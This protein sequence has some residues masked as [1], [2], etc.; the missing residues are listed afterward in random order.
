MVILK[1]LQ[2]RNL[3]KEYLMLK[4]AELKLD[5]LEAGGVDNWEGYSFSLFENG[6]TYSELCEELEKD[7]KK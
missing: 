6:N 3:Y 2:N 5:M 7:I 1:L 4:K